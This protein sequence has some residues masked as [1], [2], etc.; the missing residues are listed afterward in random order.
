MALAEAKV[1]AV[2]CYTGYHR[3]EVV[4]SVAAAALNMSKHFRALH[5]SLCRDGER[6]I[7]WSIGLVSRWM[8]SPWA[9]HSD[10]A[11]WGKLRRQCVTRPE[12]MEAMAEIA[13][14]F[15]TIEWDHH[16]GITDASATSD[17]DD[18]VEVVEQGKKR[19][20]SDELPTP[21]C[22]TVVL[23]PAS[24]AP[25]A[26]A[27]T[28][29]ASASTTSSKAQASKAAITAVKAPA[30]K[31]RPSSAS[32]LQAEENLQDEHEDRRASRPHTPS[33]KRELRPT[34][35]T[36]PPPAA[37]QSE[38]LPVN[39]VTILEEFRVDSCAGRQ[40]ELLYQQA[41]AMAGDCM[42]KL[43]KERDD[44]ITNTSAFVSRI[45]TNCRKSMTNW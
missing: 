38:V 41:P 12:A 5:L 18:E 24:K 19:K 43:T 36:N 1:Y 44:P 39:W 7:H 25:A 42:W 35:P 8:S 9:Q 17:L 13:E 3:A 15:G 28:S 29:K 22:K 11:T 16:D 27:S 14:W 32:T 26:K 40:L 45:V 37:F 4:G 31:A 20:G 6:D 23:R 34:P 33:P 10:L 30:S 2:N 21:S